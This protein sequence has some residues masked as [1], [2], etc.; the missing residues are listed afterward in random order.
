MLDEVFGFDDQKWKKSIEQLSIEGEHFISPSNDNKSA[1]NYFNAY[2][3]PKYIIIDSYGKII[4]SD[5]KR[6]SD[7]TLIDDL[8]EI[9]KD[10]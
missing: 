3:I 1:A 2:S 6:P 9:L 4:S 8:K 5:A 7:D 10:M